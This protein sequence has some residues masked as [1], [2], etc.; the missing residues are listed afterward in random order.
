M[1]GLVVG[2]LAAMAGAVFFFLNQGV[3][4]NP[5]RNRQIGGVLLAICAGVLLVGLIY[6]VTKLVAS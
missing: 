3:S 5:R 1:F 2:G 6:A 4:R